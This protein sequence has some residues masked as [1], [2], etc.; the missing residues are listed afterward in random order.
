MRILRTAHLS[1]AGLSASAAAEHALRGE[2]RPVEREGRPF[3]AIDI[4]ADSW[5]E[6]LRILL[7]KLAPLP[8]DFDEVQRARTGLYLGSSSF[9]VAWAEGPDAPAAESRD[10]MPPP[11]L[12]GRLLARRLGIAGP[13]SVFGSA[14]VASL[15]ALDAACADLA[16]GHVEHALVLGLELDNRLTREGFAALQ[17]LSPTACRPLDKARN[18][19]VLGESISALLMTRDAGSGWHVRGQG[20]A[21]DNSGPTAADLSG[22]PMIAAIERALDTAGLAL[23]DIGLV[24]LHGAGSPLTDAAEVA[25]LRSLF[26][27]APTSFSLKPYLGHCLGASGTSELSLLCACLDAGCV[28]ATPAFEMPDPALAWTPTREASDW[29][30]GAVLA[31]W[32]GFGGQVAATVL[33][34][35]A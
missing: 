3:H 20:W 25:A 1:G 30:G 6:R 35:R 23:Q 14:C 17:L 4:A 10:A 33:E 31:L 16:A 28:P 21:Y 12:L 11:A 34:R 7:D 9:F 27:Q 8:P 26:A 29:Q 24:K 2:S 32:F 15:A 22:A 5:P 19:L 13:V 18:G